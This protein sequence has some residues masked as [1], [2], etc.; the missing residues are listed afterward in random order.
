MATS[1]WRLWRCDIRKMFSLLLLYMMASHPA[2]ACCFA[3]TSQL[4]AVLLWSCCCDV[5]S[6]DAS[7]WRK[8][9]KQ[10]NIAISYFSVKENRLHSDISNNGF[11]VNSVHFQGRCNRWREKLMKKN[12]FEPQNLLLLY[13]IYYYTILVATIYLET[14]KHQCIHKRC[15]VLEK[16]LEITS[17]FFF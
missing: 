10:N 17:L 11:H 3:P 2:F 12:S 7:Y 9:C 6:F 4:F 1:V 16:T 13:F 15:R 14:Y 8:Y 5:A